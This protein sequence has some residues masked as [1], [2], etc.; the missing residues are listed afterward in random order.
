M[1]GITRLIGRSK[2]GVQMD[3][4][5]R[6][7]RYFVA[8]AECSGFRRAAE[9][10]RV[11]QPALTR[12]IRVFEGEMNAELFTRSFRG[13]ELTDAGRQLFEDA[14]P[15][16]AAA[17]SIRSRLTQLPRM[18]PRVTVGFVQGITIAPMVKTLTS[19]HPNVHV[20]LFCVRV[21]DQAEMT[22]GGR[23]DVCF[24][25]D[26]VAQD[27]LN[28]VPLYDEPRLVALPESDPL[29]KVGFLELRD[30][31]RFRLL[32]PPES[33]PE[34]RG[35]HTSARPVNELYGD[36]HTFTTGTIEETLEHVA[37]DHGIAILP[38]STAAMHARPDISYRRVNG[39]A[40][41]QVALA[42]SPTHKSRYVEEIID[43]AI[44]QADEGA[45]ISDRGQ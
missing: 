27:G 31:L 23:V 16:L 2:R 5:L 29:A 32:Q 22:L 35:L 21:E 37:S 4:D 10:L 44:R 20:D 14:Q 39:L 9:V 42:Y 17:D 34:L 6:K 18:V 28:L 15:L 26:V 13:A 38:A 7:L 19:H 24:G 41:S 11:A 45:V 33:V 30:L 36:T 43:V 8:V 25:R 40:V 1:V 12:Q 3:L